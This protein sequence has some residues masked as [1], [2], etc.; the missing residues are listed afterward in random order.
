MSE[1]P[2]TIAGIV[3]ELLG[4]A[5]QDDVP[6]A[7]GKEVIDEI[8]EENSEWDFEDFHDKVIRLHHNATEAHGIERGMYSWRSFKNFTVSD[9]FE[10][11]FDVGKL[12]ELVAQKLDERNY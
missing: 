12:R 10:D 7:V 11:W 5:Y 9:I 1:R 8:I 4:L 6:R 3:S 2:G